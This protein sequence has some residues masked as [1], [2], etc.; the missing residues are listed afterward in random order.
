M[1]KVKKRSVDSVKRSPVRKTSYEAPTVSRR[2]STKR[3]VPKEYQTFKKAP[4]GT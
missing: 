4:K 3:K 2:K 1:A